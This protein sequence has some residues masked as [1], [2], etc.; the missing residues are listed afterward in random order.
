[1]V[2]VYDFAD[3][4]GQRVNP[5]GVASSAIPVTQGAKDLLIDVLQPAGAQRK[6]KAHGSE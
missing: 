6:S 3:L 2:A 5:D 1:M 4:T